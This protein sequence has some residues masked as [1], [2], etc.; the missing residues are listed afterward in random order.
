MRFFF[1][2]VLNLLI[3]SSL[4]LYNFHYT[5][6]Q[7]GSIAG[8]IVHKNKGL[9]FLNIQLLN[10]N[11]GTTSD[12]LGQ[13]QL[14]NIPFGAYQLKV[15]GIGFKS[16]EQKISV[17]QNLISLKIELEEELNQLSEI[18]ISG[19]MKETFLK[20]SPVPIEVFS[21]KFFQKNP[22][23][24]LFDALVNVNGVRPQL[25]CNVCNTGDIHINGMEGAYTMVLIDGMPIVSS[26]STVYGLMG[27]PNSII[28]RVEIVKGPAS[29][30][31]GSEAVGGLINIITKSPTKAPQLLIDLNTS[32]YGEWNTD[33]AAKYR[34]GKKISALASANYFNFQRI[35]DKNR[36]NFT[37]LTLQNRISIFNKINFERR[38]NRVAS[39][40]VRYMY[41]DRWGGEVNWQPKFRGGEE[42]YGES[43][44]T[45]R[46][47]LIGNYQLPVRNEKVLLAYSFNA[48]QQNSVYGATK[49]LADQ[50]IAFGQLTWDK[51]I[52][53]HDFLL[54]STLRFTYYD[55]NTPATAEIN[56]RNRPDQ[57]FL[58]GV[59]AQDE[60]SLNDKHKLLLGLRYDYHSQQG[61][62]FTPRLAYKWSLNENNNLRLNIGRG[63]RVVNLFTEDHA[64][65]TGAR[66]VVILENLRP[67]QSWNVN[68]NYQ[69]N[70]QASF[71]QINLDGSLFYTHFSNQIIADYLTNSDQIIYDNLKGHAISQ[72]FT[73]NSDWSFHF[74]L[75]IMA[76]F[77]WLEVYQKEVD[78]FGKS[79]RINQIQTPNF[80]G[81]FTIS[82]S[83]EKAK[84]SIDW[85]GNVF[86]PMDL[87]VLEND[88]RP[89]QSPWFS[90]QNI[91]WTKK[92]RNGLDIYLGIKNLFNFIPQNPIMHP[93]DPFDRPGGKYWLADST[94]NL[95]TNP[96]G[97]TFDPTYNFA[98]I[99][100][101]RG[102]LGVRWT[103]N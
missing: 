96:N 78:E 94:P 46:W 100:G 103:L 21:P 47:E 83:F 98:P 101:I 7:N 93:D 81:T 15:T 61:N 34:V 32:T 62:I 1:K 55:D 54:G 6:A 87:P 60:I 24:C 72:G 14:K 69:R 22:T 27:I 52:K 43:I 53:K 23:A 36:D 5:L 30:L 67:E 102:F 29:S 12:S 50:K 4:Y 35:R 17:N 20:E 65:L 73:F 86:S 11:F 99:Q 68:L 49:Y 77:T 41:E 76:G 3:Y 39:L 38:E 40:A 16:Y 45:S 88:F 84:M 44:Y 90:L 58:P 80:S 33:L 8:K 70:I 91:Q 37:D 26:L 19:T 25:G 64:A 74:P 2:F 56:Q 82:Y 95:Q 89:S 59:F 85:T 18:V 9:E 48:H 63:F 75:K 28:E 92:F 79:L 31:Y 42:V 10:T 71:G 13:F 57:I 51:K 66:E 97:Y